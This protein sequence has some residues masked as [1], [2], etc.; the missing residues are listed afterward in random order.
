MLFLWIGGHIS[1]CVVNVK[2]TNLD[3]LCFIL[4]F[5]NHFWM[6]SRL[7]CSFSEVQCGSFSV[8]TTAVLLVNVA[9]GDSGEVVRSAVY[10]SPRILPGCTLTLR[11]DSLVY[12]L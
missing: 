11:L 10:S 4:N 5:F 8:T 1:L 6:T 2:W 7:V 12:S 9:E 3:P